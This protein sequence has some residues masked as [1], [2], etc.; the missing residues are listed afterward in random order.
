MFEFRSDLETDSGGSTVIKEVSLKTEEDEEDESEWECEFRSDL[1][2]GLSIE[3]EE[4]S[5]LEFEFRSDLG[6]DLFAE[7]ERL[8]RLREQDLPLPVLSQAEKTKVLDL[9]GRMD[10]HTAGA[11]EKKKK[12]RR[13]K[14]ECSA[15]AR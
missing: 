11:K 13:K 8:V 9:M 2:D 5:D 6:D 7:G 1:G 14:G 15:R 3:G 10:F 12:R 4:D